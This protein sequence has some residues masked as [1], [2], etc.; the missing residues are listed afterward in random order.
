M[1][2]LNLAIG[3]SCFVRCRG[4][5]NYFGNTARTG[6]LVSAEE[7]LDFLCEARMLGVTQITISGGD[8]LTHPEIR[9]IL[10][11]IS[12]LGLTTKVDTV[13]TALITDAS[14]RFYG[15]GTIKQFSA[16]D[17]APYIDTLGLPLDGS[18]EETS[19]Q[20][21]AGRENLTNEVMKT[22]VIAKEAGIR[23]CVNTV[24]HRGNLADLSR[25]MGLVVSSG[26]DE[27]QIFE[28]QP[29]GSL[30]SRAANLLK[31]DPGE[32]HSGTQSLLSSNNHSPN[33]KIV[34]KSRALREGAYFLVDDAGV[35]WIPA[36]SGN[37]RTVIGHISTDRKRVLERLKL[38]IRQR[39]FAGSTYGP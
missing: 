3:P 19:S 6:G 21:R 2:N 16:R 15:T 33:L 34:Y 7:A 9:Q 11:G 28:F 25:V 38:H 17:I 20:F 23:V 35:A 18:S 39:E 31:L 1:P 36:A 22:I 32:F 8:P 10:M 27:W 5:Y 12:R 24:A 13:G 4:C 37:R 29:T 14:V 30:G 26:A